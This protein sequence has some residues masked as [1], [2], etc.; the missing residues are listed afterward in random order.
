MQITDGI[1]AIA[2][3]N[4]LEA[5]ARGLNLHLRRVCELASTD[6]SLVYRWQK[7]GVVPLLNN[8]RRVTGLIDAKLDELEAEMAARIRRRA[9]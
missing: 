1:D 9:S 8:F 2:A 6:Y 7:R 5:R 3:I 4:A